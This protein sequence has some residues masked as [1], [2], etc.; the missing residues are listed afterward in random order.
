[1]FEIDQI[2][3]INITNDIEIE[4]VKNEQLILIDKLNDLLNFLNNLFNK[5]LLNKSIKN[6]KTNK[7]KIID[8]FNKYIKGNKISANIEHHG[9]EGH[10]LETQ[11]RIPHNSNNKPDIFGYEMKKLST[12]ITFGDFS[13]SEYLFSRNRDVINNINRWELEDFVMSRSDFIKT[14]GTPNVKKNN[15]CSWS[16]SCVPIYNEWNN[17]G[18]IIK[19]TPNNDIHIYYSYSKDTR[20]GKEKF[21]KLLKKDDILIVIWFKK[22]LQAHI[23]KKFNSNGFFI[24]K[25]IGPTYQKIC[26]GVPFDYEYFIDNIK[27]KYIIFDSGMY[28]GNNRNYS[29][30]RSSY[31]KFWRNL[32]IVED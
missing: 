24:C 16:G 19:I 13:A 5:I 25:K 28:D 20:T 6:D 2:N 31:N 12:K 18:Q 17:C 1:M 21:H 7:E 22:K 27:K 10:W 15:R 8:L 11:M 4:K 30:F 29:M 26:F 14:F 3:N 23:N 9:K 32:I